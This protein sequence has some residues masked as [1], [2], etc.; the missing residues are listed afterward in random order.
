MDRSTRA[1]RRSTGYTVSS[2]ESSSRALRAAQRRVN[3]EKVVSKR[4]STGEND[5]KTTSIPKGKLPV[6]RKRVTNTNKFE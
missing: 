5:E 2:K 4:K 3:K 6:I 1:L